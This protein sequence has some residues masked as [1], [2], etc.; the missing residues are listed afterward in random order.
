MQE[1]VRVHPGEVV[2]AL[3]AIRVSSATG[4]AA[5]IKLYTKAERVQHFQHL[6]LLVPPHHRITPDQ[7]RNLRSSINWRLRVLPFGHLEFLHTQSGV[8]ADASPTTWHSPIRSTINFPTS[9]HSQQ[10]VIHLPRKLVCIPARGQKRYCSLFL[11]DRS[12]PTLVQRPKGL[13]RIYTARRVISQ[14]QVS[15]AFRPGSW[16]P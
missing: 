6:L 8:H 7:P 4:I 12:S 16:L 3:S 10:N 2:Q 13:Q 9:V 1:R 11:P 5:E 15:L 14:I